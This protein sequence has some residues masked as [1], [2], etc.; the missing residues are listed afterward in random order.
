MAAGELVEC[1]RRGFVGGEMDQQALLV[2]VGELQ[3]LEGQPQLACRGMVPPLDSGAPGRPGWAR[4]RSV[5][6]APPVTA[7]SRA[8]SAMSGPAHGRTPA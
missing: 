6:S 3:R 4:I 8:N 5:N 2:G 7:G 1:G